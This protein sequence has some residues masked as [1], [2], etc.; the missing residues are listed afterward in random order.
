MGVEPEDK[1]RR[2]SNSARHNAH[3]KRLAWHLFGRA[4][5]VT[6]VNNNFVY[7]T[8]DIRNLVVREA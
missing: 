7:S 5:Q 1:L 2:G 3:D 4:G 8:S 6:L